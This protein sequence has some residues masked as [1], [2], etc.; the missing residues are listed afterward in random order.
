[1]PELLDSADIERLS[2]DVLDLMGT[3]CTIE[4][5]GLSGGTT[6]GAWLTRASGVKCWVW[7]QGQALPVL[8]ASMLTTG[9]LKQAGSRRVLLPYNQ[10]VKSGDRLHIGSFYYSVQGDV[11]T[12]TDFRFLTVVDVEIVRVAQT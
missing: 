7:E 6:S 8:M 10:T 11:K 4:Y 5:Q 3:T 12:D 9:T 1:M 2:D